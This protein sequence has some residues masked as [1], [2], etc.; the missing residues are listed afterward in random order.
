MSKTGLMFFGFGV[1]LIVLAL[2]IYFKLRRCSEPVK[3][4]VVGKCCYRGNI[5]W[6]IFTTINLVVE[7]EYNGKTYRGQTLNSLTL[8]TTSMDKKLEKM[9]Y[10]EGD[11]CTIKVNPKKPQDMCT[12]YSVNP[13]ILL[14][15]ALFLLMGLL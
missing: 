10:K 13:V 6:S 14:G 11:E 12:K 15:A 5:A 8:L 7:Y 3:A 9:G 4:K 1:L 2:F